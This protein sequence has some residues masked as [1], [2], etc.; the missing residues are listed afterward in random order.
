MNG[1]LKKLCLSVT[2]VILLVVACGPSAT[3]VAPTPVP[4]TATPVTPTPV[5]PT[6]TPVPP[7][8]VPPTAT[9]VPPTIAPPTATRVVPTP[10]PPT[11][12]P[13][14]VSIAV[15]FAG[16]T[17]TMEGPQQVPYGAVLVI[18]W[19][20]EDTNYAV[21]GLC[22][23]TVDPG[24]TLAD[25]QAAPGYPQPSWVHL[26]YGDCWPMDYAATSTTVQVVM[27]TGPAYII[28]FGSQTAKIGAL[29]PIEVVQ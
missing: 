9:V 14:R 6:A 12:T 4:P 16:G 20:L 2:L 21:P 11:A 28:C 1:Q 23:V 15:T 7:T 3:P 18:Q 10:G 27:K 19:T 25:L 13:V 8:P 26:T 29:G 22:M 17:C 24:K 5:P